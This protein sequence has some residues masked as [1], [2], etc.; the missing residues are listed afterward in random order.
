MSPSR[1]RPLPASDV[2]KDHCKVLFQDIAQRLA[3]GIRFHE[4]LVQACQDRFKSYKIL[5]LVVYEENVTFVSVCHSCAH[6]MPIVG[7]CVWLT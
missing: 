3:T 4:M 5:R 7:L 2:Q 6:A 1:I